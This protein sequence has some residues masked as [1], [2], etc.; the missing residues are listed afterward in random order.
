[1]LSC[2]VAASVLAQLL[3]AGERLGP[4]ARRRRWARSSAGRSRALF[5]TVGT[6]ILV[7][8]VCVAALIVGTQFAFLKLCALAWT[9][10]RRWAKAARARA[11]ACW[12]A[13]K[14]L[15]RGA[16]RA[17]KEK[18]EEA[19]FLAQLEA[20]EEELAEA[21]RDAAEAEAM[22]EEAERLAG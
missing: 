20:D 13:Q 10:R 2:W 1:M 8:A 18:Q 12:A 19:A 5:S 15:R 3:F 21:E 17:A 9:R 16:R 22:A 4:R 11:A 6:V 7:G 14:A